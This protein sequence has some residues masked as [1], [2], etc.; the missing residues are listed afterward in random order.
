M[1]YAGIF[2]SHMLP[3][4]RRGYRRALKSVAARTAPPA[5]NGS[6]GLSEEVITWAH[7]PPSTISG[8]WD[9]PAV[10]AACRPRSAAVLPAAATASERVW[11]HRAGCRTHR[12]LPRAHPAL[13]PRRPHRW[14]CRRDL[15]AAR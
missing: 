15:R 9:D 13:R 11:D 12:D 3:S 7:S 8:A 1:T 14:D 6:F 10:S 4:T 2:T 5:R